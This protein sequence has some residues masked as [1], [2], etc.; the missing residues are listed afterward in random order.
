[1]RMLRERSPIK[2]VYEF[3]RF[4]LMCDYADRQIPKSAHFWWDKHRGAWVTDSHRVA[5]GLIMF[6]NADAKKRILEVVTSKP[7]GNPA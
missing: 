1:M 2:M 7:T 3:G 5:S 6:A 4:V